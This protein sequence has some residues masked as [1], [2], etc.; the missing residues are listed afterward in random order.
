MT[1]VVPTKP[2]A[3]S[4]RLRLRT[5]LLII[6]LGALTLLATTQ[7]WWTIHVPTKALDVVGTA[8]APALAALALSS[9]ALAAALTIA[10]PVFRIILGVL[11]IVLGATALFSS[12]TSISSPADASSSLITAST[13]VAGDKSVAALVES[14]DFTWWPWLAIVSAVL[15]ILVG[16]FILV[17]FR[18]WPMASRKYQAVRL[19][20][21]SAPRDSVGDWDALSGGDDPTSD[22]PGSR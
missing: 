7:K 14:V 20:D 8:A 11:E 5:I 3:A 18:R 4:R 19:D 21:P 22:Q 12:L 16:L 2:S 9:F 13:G 15:T 10:G 1:D 17:S 6:V